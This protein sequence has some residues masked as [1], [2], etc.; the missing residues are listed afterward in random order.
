MERASTEPGADALDTLK[1]DLRIQQR[2]SEPSHSSLQP[3]YSFSLDGELDVRRDCSGAL[4]HWLILI[5]C[6][7]ASTNRP[8]DD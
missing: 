8:R 3:G 7:E 1:I 2:F 4:G 6:G 5:R